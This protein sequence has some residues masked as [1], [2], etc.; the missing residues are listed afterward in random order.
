L[1]EIL[2]DLT[3]V[4]E[5]AGD[6]KARVAMLSRKISFHSACASLNF[7]KM[8]INDLLGNNVPMDRR[9]VVDAATVRVV[10]T[11]DGQIGTM[12]DVRPENEA[13]LKWGGGVFKT[14]DF[15][16]AAKWR[17]AL[18][19]NGLSEMTSLP[20]L[21]FTLQSLEQ[22]NTLIDTMM[23]EPEFHLPLIDWFHGIYWL[24]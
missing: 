6:P 13:L 12:R 10:K 5:H 23:I 4:P 8:A 22:V 24:R 20:K 1:Y 11:T 14:D 2:A 16:F 17:E 21:D 19:A 7:R 9:P 18:A 3:L 15:E